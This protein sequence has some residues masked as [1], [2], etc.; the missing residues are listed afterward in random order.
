MIC[1]APS[2]DYTALL[3]DEDIEIHPLHQLSRKGT[4]PLQDIRLINELK[5]TYRKHGIDL[6]IHFTIKPNIYGS[7]A[8]RQAH[9]PSI[10]VITGLGYTFHT[11]GLTNRSAQVLY[12]LAFRKNQLTIFQ[13]PDDRAL[14][15]QRKL[16][17]E[18]RS[19]VILG[20]GIDTD[21]FAEHPSFPV[22]TTFLFIG[23]L[24]HDKGIRELLNGFAIFSEKHPESRLIILGEPDAQ[25]PASVSELDLLRYRQ[26]RAIHFAG[27]QP[28]VRTFIQ[29]A[30][31]VVLPSYREGVPKTLLEA[32]SIGRPVI[33]TDVPG[34]REVVLPGENGLLIPSHNEKALAKALEEFH[35]LDN[36]VKQQMGRKSRELAETHFSTRVVNGE[37]LDWVRRLL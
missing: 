37:F 31:A 33:T 20:S 14:F 36:A 34:C 35:L 7:I 22:T 16:V 26:H 17:E 24:L 12:R 29:Q 28:D 1:F 4:N 30:S 11:R 8:A 18:S 2:D 25:N 13:N 5:R 32:L 6:A 21:S 19:T 3:A 10:S 9:I 23:R 27:F 15:V